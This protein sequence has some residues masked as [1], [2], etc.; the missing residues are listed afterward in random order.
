[1][2]EA[3]PGPR[4]GSR[5]S[6]ERTLR[7]VLGGWLLAAIGALA[8]LGLPLA[9]F[10]ALVRL[11]KGGPWTSDL[12]FE[13]LAVAPMGLDTGLPAGDDTLISYNQVMVASGAPLVGA[14]QLAVV[15][16]LAPVATFVIGC[17]LTLLLV[18]T[19]ATGRPFARLLVVALSVAS[20]LVLVTAVLEPWALMTS[21]EL[22]VHELGLPTAA[23]PGVD[24]GSA[25]WVVPHSFGFENVSWPVAV[26]GL[27]LG[28]LAV[29]VG[30]GRQLE[31]DVEGL[32]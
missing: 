28:L 15:G 21:V 1:M 31:R 13:V 25:V 14:R 16:L 4:G 11:S 17:L 30:R 23:A 12:I 26:L 29:V 6:L 3:A 32:V 5:R 20:V 19:I 27:V 7:Q 8:V 2:S 18:V 24:P 10:V 9:A 22:A